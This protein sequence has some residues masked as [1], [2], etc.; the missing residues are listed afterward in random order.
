MTSRRTV[1][2]A[3]NQAAAL[4]R[5]ADAMDDPDDLES[6]V[7]GGSS[8]RPSLG[9]GARHDDAREAEEIRAELRKSAGEVLGEA[10]GGGRVSRDDDAEEA[11]RVDEEKLIAEQLAEDDT[12]RRRRCWG[13]II[14][15]PFDHPDY[16][17][18][19]TSRPADAH[20]HMGS[21][22]RE[23][24]EYELS[25]AASEDEPPVRKVGFA[26][27]PADP[28]AE[29]GGEGQE[30]RGEEAEKSPGEQAEDRPAPATTP[31]D[32]SAKEEERRVSFNGS[33]RTPRDDDYKE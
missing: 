29:A 20:I 23:V 16:P 30:E 11:L 25:P 15:K 28:H 8:S 12:K 13:P 7:S 32:T 33:A 27:F 24:R 14:R 18:P 5:V 6:R 2:I 22:V 26:N 4:K 31:S 10:G 17:T 21:P 9:V 1:R 19:G 3:G